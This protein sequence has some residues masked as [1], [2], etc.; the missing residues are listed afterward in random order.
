[1]ADEQL[2][3]SMELFFGIGIIIASIIFVRLAIKA[4]NIGAFRFQ[5]SLFILLWVM[6]EAPRV[7]STLGLISTAGFGLYG[8][9]LHMASMF[10]FALFIGAKSYRFLHAKPPFPSS[11]EGATNLPRPPTG[12]IEQ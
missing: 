3:E 4:K 2:I 10:A 12:K 1:M 6:A 9:T 5:L 7:L 8:L 11:I